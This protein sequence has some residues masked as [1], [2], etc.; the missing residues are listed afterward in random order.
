MPT[1]PRLNQLN[2]AFPPY[3]LT[4]VMPG[5]SAVPLGGQPSVLG[6]SFTLAIP[7]NSLELYAT[8]AALAGIASSIVSLAT[9][10]QT[11]IEPTGGVRVKDLLDPYQYQVVSQALVANAQPIPAGTPV[12]VITANPLGGAMAV[13]GTLAGL[14]AGAA[15]VASTAGLAATSFLSGSIAAPNPTAV[16]VGNGFP[17]YFA[18]LVVINSALGVIGTALGTM[19]TLVNASVDVPSRSLALKSV[20][21][22]FQVA[23]NS[24]AAGIAGRV[25]PTPTF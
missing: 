1:I 2:I 10:L 9:A 15:A 14:A 17:D 21:G 3:N 6:A 22:I 24:Q 4:G 23:L 16:I 25:A 12:E 19:A 8:G 11:V 18:P 20:L 5:S 7:D 13:T